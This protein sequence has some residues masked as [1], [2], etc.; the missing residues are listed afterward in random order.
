M[1]DSFDSPDFDDERYA[2]LRV[3][4]PAGC[5]P[6]DWGRFALKCERPGVS[7]LG[8]VADTV[9]EIRRDH[10]VVL[11]S[12]GIEKPGEWYGEGRDGYKA[13]IVAHLLLSAVYRAELIGYG[14]EE[15]IRLLDS[16][17]IE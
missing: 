8:A 3:R 13:E 10:G 16:T 12:L 11:N 7:L 17:G 9:D 1:D 4:P 6:A 5:E 2:S 14:R 15:L